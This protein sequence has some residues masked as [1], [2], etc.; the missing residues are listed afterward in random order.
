MKDDTSKHCAEF[1]VIYLTSVSDVLRTGGL[2]GG[3]M[4]TSSTVFDDAPPRI[5]H[6]RNQI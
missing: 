1:D 6:L 4:A 3:F 2:Q 5:G